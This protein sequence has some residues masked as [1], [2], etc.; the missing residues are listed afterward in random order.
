MTGAK[1]APSESL[2]MAVH[3]PVLYIG[4][5]G[6]TVPFAYAIGALALGVPGPEWLRRSHRSTLVAWSFLTLGS[7]RRLVGLRGPLLGRILGLGS[8]GER[9]AHAMACCHS[10]HPLR[11]GPTTARDAPGMELR[12]RDQRL[13]SPSSEHSSPARAR[14]TPSIHSLNPRSG[15]RSSDSWSWSSSDPSPSSPWSHLVASSPRI[16]TFVS[17]EGTFLINNLL[18]TVYAFVVLIGTTHP[19]ARGLHRDPGGRW[20][21]LLQ[22]PR[23]AFVFHAAPDDGVR[24]GHALGGAPPGL[25][26]RRL[27]WPTMIALALGL[28]VALTVT[29]PG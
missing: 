20:R 19:L 22:P 2:L 12:S 8:G 14:S 1:P 3:P 23:S 5:V 28:V 13:P 21:A 11:V 16:E 24:T 17:R 26:W 29:W 27:R 6:L 4:Y 18:L 10:L 9:F 25:L 15:L 7:P